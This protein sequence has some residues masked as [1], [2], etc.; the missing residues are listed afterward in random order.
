MWNNLYSGCKAPQRCP[1]A[2]A[3]VQ[4]IKALLDVHKEFSCPN[5]L[6]DCLIAAI[7]IYEKAQLKSYW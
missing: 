2:D 5:Y 7:G 6:A 3:L 1:G 4:I